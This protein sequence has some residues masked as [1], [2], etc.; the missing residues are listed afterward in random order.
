MALVRVTCLLGLIGFLAGWSV[1]RAQD[2]QEG[3]SESRPSA[4]EIFPE[5]AKAA[6]E[7]KPLWEYLRERTK[8]GYGYD[9]TYD[10]NSLRQD[11]NKQED[12]IST[13]ETQIFFVDARGSLETSASYEVN[14]FR[15]HRRDANALNHDVAALIE[16]DPGGPLQYEFQ[17]DLDVS[18]RLVLTPEETDLFRRGADF[19]PEAVHQWSGGLTYTT[20]PRDEIQ[21]RPSYSL[22]DDQTRNDQDTDRRELTVRTI[23]EHE[24]RERWHLLTG[25]E[26]QD[27]LVPGNKDKDTSAHLGRIG[28]RFDVTEEA[29]IEGVL[30]FGT[31][32]FGSGESGDETQFE[33]ISEYPIPITPRFSAQLNYGDTQGASS[34]SGQT[35]VRRRSSKLGL[36]Y[37]LTPLITL[38]SEAQYIKQRSTASG[39]AAV[40]SRLYLLEAGLTW[41]LRPKAA[42]QLKSRYERSKT[43]DYVDRQI[44]LEF[45]GEL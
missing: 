6:E 4:S 16:W 10:D 14:A 23:W 20:S 8:L 26:F 40:F 24:L 1:A 33:L 35:K 25:Y 30:K 13:L 18:H 12:F 42:L 5:R 19:Q 38:S 34:V 43:I 7:K 3:L 45:E 36:K 2:L 41:Q 39:K 28:L 11:N 15:Y 22:K 37:E 9:L 17:Y 31:R 21:L 32:S 44:L 27:I 29:D